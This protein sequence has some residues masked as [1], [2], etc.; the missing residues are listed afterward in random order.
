MSFIID[1]ST[2]LEAFY[3]AAENHE[4]I[5]KS[6]QFYGGPKDDDDAELSIE[7]CFASEDSDI[8]DFNYTC[9]WDTPHHEVMAAI[10]RG[11]REHAAGVQGDGASEHKAAEAALAAA[12]KK[13]MAAKEIRLL[14]PSALEALAMEAP[15]EGAEAA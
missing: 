12:T 6:V 13:V 14:A 7:I 11:I 15:D 5:V 2:A 10:E 4:D 8:A 3:E 1:I 9:S